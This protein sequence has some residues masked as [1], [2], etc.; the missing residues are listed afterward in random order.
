M[1][2]S[3]TAIIGI[4]YEQPVLLAEAAA[5]ADLLSGGR[6][7][8]GLG[9]GQGGYDAVFGQAPNDGREVAQAH[10]ETFLAGAARPGRRLRGDLAR[11]AEVSDPATPAT[12]H[13]GSAWPARCCPLSDEVIAFLPPAFDL[14]GNVR[15]LEDIATPVA[16]AL[17]WNPATSTATTGEDPR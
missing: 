17:G 1:T 12:G 7:Q 8:L 5:T 14:A 15:L 13:H 9:T 4:R 11:A 6:P 10:L 3:L 16:P 2:L